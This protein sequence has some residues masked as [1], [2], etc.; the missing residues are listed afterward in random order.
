M[1]KVFES[2][3]IKADFSSMGQLDESEEKEDGE[4]DL[5]GLAAAALAAVHNLADAAGADVSTTVDTGE[6]D[7]EDVEE[8]T[9]KG[10]AVKDPIVKGE[11]A[12]TKSGGSKLQKASPGWKAVSDPEDVE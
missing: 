9:R 6:E 12:Y 7:E 11:K 8:G 2:Q 4:E 5:E 10:Q 3:G 1:Q